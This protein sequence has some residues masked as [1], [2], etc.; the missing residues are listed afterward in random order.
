MTT[1]ITLERG[2]GGG[3]R[4]LRKWHDQMSLPLEQSDHNPGWLW[5]LEAR[6]YGQGI[7][8]PEEIALLYRYPSFAVTLS[9]IAFISQ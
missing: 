7:L 9:Y 3:S 4:S 5:I 2:G 6:R 1:R 8:Q